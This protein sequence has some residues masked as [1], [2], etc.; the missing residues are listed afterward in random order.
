MKNILKIVCVAISFIAISIGSAWACT[1]EIGDFVWNDQNSN[2]IQ[3][4]GEPGMV[5]ITVY[6]EDRYY[7][8]LQTT[9]TDSSGK[10]LFTDLQMD[11]YVVEFV[12]PSGFTFTLRGQGTD[13]TVDSNAYPRGHSNFITLSLDRPVNVNIDAGLR[14]SPVP[15]PGTV[16]LLGSGLLP[17]A[18]RRRGRMSAR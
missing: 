14:A 6:L 1:G 2:G 11:K 7:N 12:A 17:L 10:Y 15:L 8:V 9:I 5:G 18:I 13:W 3:D 16:F 4:P